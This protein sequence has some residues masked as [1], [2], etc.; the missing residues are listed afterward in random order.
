MRLR[1]LG[2]VAHIGV[3]VGWL[4]AAV[5]SLAVAVTGLAA[6]EPALA[7]AAYLVLEPVGW[8]TL[9]PLGVAS[10]VTGV[11]QS[12]GTSWGL[13][14]HYWVLF[15]LMMNLFAVGVLLLYMRTLGQLAALARS[16]DAPRSP[17][18]VVHAAAAIVLLLV[19]LVLS[20]YKPRGRTPWET[21]VRR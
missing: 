2:L 13:V 7:R 1:R 8:W 15:K 20:V 6:R 18:P 3:S 4:G 9:V 17:S 19:A 21:S 5:A 14:R 12:L 16:G 10:L 11:V